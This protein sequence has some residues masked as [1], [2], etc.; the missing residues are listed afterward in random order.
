[1]DQP[2]APPQPNAAQSTIIAVALIALVGLMFW[3]ATGKTADKDL[4]AIVWA[5]T[6]TIVGVVAGAVPSFFFRAQA[7]AEKARADTERHRAATVSDQ[8]KQLAVMVPPNHIEDA[9][10]ILGNPGM[11]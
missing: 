5:G 6:G 9:Q 8:A 4:F 7:T 10:R 2:P 11:R 3:R 1:M